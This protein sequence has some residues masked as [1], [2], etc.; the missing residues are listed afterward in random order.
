M[1][2]RTP[3]VD[4]KA[5][6]PTAE[7]QEA[8]KRKRETMDSKAKLSVKASVRH[9][10]RTY[11]EENKKTI[12]PKGEIRDEVID[13]WLVHLARC[14]DGDKSVK[15][16]HSF[17]KTSSKFA[18]LEWYSKETLATTFGTNR[19]KFWLDDEL[20]PRRP[21]RISGKHGEWITEFAV[22]NDWERLTEADLRRLRGE[23]EFALSKENGEEEM[24]SL[25]ELGG[26]MLNSGVSG[27]SS[28]TGEGYTASVP[29]KK[30]PTPGEQMAE[31]VEALIAQKD[32][33]LQRMRSHNLEARSMSEKAKRRQKEQGKDAHLLFIGEC[34]KIEG[35]SKKAISV[36]ERMCIEGE[37]PV[38][39]MLPKL[40]KLT[41]QTDELM[42]EAL[43][44]GRKFQFTET[45]TKGDGKRKRK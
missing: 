10:V 22:P 31:K 18:D 14:A 38:A 36:L 13:G 6:M 43:D 41:E 7:E 12:G 23:V 32:Q 28:S 2:K 11:K 44:W 9:F 33:T 30:E 35:Q 4:L 27:S 40:V 39:D 45:I 5:V 3:K 34:G 1:V 16:E 42:N 26:M 21:C 17:E 19:S 8:A 25:M 20:L 15:N 37:E 29:I 24:Q